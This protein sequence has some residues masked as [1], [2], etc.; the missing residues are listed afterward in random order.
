VRSGWRRARSS[1]RSLRPPLSETASSFSSSGA[2]GRGAA[3]AAPR[4]E[5]ID[6]SAEVAMPRSLAAA[7]PTMG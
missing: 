7:P 2:G 3:S 1:S 6:W 4:A 5:D